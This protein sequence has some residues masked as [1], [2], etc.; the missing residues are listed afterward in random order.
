MGKHMAPAFIIKL[1]DIISEQIYKDIITWDCSL[2]EVRISNVAKF[3]NEVLSKHFKNKDFR[4]FFRQLALYEFVRTSDGRKTRGMGLDTHCS[5]AHRF[6][7]PLRP[8]DIHLIR[9]C[10]N[11]NYRPKR[12]RPRAMLSE[13]PSSRLSVDWTNLTK[14]ALASDIAYP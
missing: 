13:L 12:Q 8:L 11:Y 2:T 7:S 1:Y 3:E 5:F 4:S 14:L 10:K 6:F 9:R